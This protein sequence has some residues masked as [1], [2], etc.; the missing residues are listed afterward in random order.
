MSFC[1]THALLLFVMLS[2][3]RMRYQDRAGGGRRNKGGPSL[4]CVYISSLVLLSGL[5]SVH[6][7][8]PHHHNTTLNHTKTQG[9]QP[10]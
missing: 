8:P 4:D 7:Q 5:I 1:A 3:M 6:T 2:C 10:L 9:N